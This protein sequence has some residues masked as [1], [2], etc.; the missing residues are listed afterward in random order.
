MLHATVLEPEERKSFISHDFQGFSHLSTLPDFDLSF[1]ECKSVG[2]FDAAWSAE[3]LVRIEFL[4]EL[5]Q[6]D[7]GVSCP[8]SLRH[9]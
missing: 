8:R 2:E 7:A 9:N 6:L 3:I 1:G 4:F 5:H